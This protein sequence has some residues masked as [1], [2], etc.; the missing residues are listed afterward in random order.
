MCDLCHGD[1]MILK[2]NTA[3]FCA[4]ADGQRRKR[5]WHEAGERVK[6]E[7]EKDRRRRARAYKDMPKAYSADYKADAAGN[8][9]RWPGEEG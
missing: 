9:E 6:L 2:D 4:C 3:V 1:G 8:G 5:L 7:V